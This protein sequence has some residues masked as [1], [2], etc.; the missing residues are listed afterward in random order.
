MAACGATMVPGVGAAYVCN[1]D[2][3]HKTATVSQPQG[4]PHED[5]TRTDGL[6]GQTIKWWS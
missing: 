5:S 3:S 1:K 4:T 2:A 6:T